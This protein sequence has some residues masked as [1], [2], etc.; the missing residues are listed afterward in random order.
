MTD[1]CWRVTDA[2][3]RTPHAQRPVADASLSVTPASLGATVGGRFRAPGPA[4][5]A[6][7]VFE[8][9]GPVWPTLGG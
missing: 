1:A 4:S 5:V 9:P 6:M 7:P 8:G 3:R 2:A